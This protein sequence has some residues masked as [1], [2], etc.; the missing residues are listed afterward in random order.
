M[1]PHSL[2]IGDKE[3]EINPSFDVCMRIILAYEDPDLMEHVKARVMFDLLFK[4]KPPM[5]EESLVAA[6]SF[7]DGGESGTRSTSISS[8]AARLYSFTQDMQ[9]I[10]AAI[11]RTHGVNLRECDDIH[12]WKFL[13]MFLELAE[14]TTFSRMIQLRH[15]KSKNK[16]TKEEK[17]LWDS[18][19]DIL[20]LKTPE[21]RRAEV[22]AQVFEAELERLENLSKSKGAT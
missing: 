8:T 9:Y 21:T 17:K 19:K 11:Q 13:D 4:D 18:M 20:V 15:Q 7:L 2:I 16:L 6:A 10:R 22:E 14:D 1:L 12:W 3:Y 5:D